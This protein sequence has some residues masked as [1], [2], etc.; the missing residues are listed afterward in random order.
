MMKNARIEALHSAKSAAPGTLQ[1]LL[2][3]D[4]KLKSELVCLQCYRECQP[5]VEDLALLSG[6]VAYADRMVS[7]TT[8][9]GWGREIEILLPVSEPD[10]W[11]SKKVINSLVGALDLVTGDCWHIRFSKAPAEVNSHRQ[12]QF[13]KDEAAPPIVIPF[14]DGLDS[15]ATLRLQSTQEPKRPFVLVTVGNGSRN[16]MRRGLQL[17][18][19]SRL[20]FP[21]SMNDS[22]RKDGHKFRESSYRSRAFAYTV[23]AG[24]VAFLRNAERVVIPES[25]QGV[26]GPWLQ[27]VGNEALDIRTHPMFTSRVSDFLFEVIGKRIRFE[28]PRLFHTKAETLKEANLCNDEGWKR[29]RSCP[30]D[31]RY[32]SIDHHHY[33][34]GVCSACLLRRMAVWNAGLKEEAP[35]YWHNLAAATLREAA[36]PGARVPT[37][38]DERIARAGV[39]SHIQLA[40]YISTRGAQ[41]RIWQAAQELSELISIQPQ[42]AAH[43]ITR[44]VEQHR[45][46]WAA[47]EASFGENSMMSKW[48]ELVA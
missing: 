4:L 22:K 23:M 41:R 17:G 8:S 43:R 25:G 9:Q 29:T 45:A 31:Q 26:L 47:F 21:F 34:C 16:G 15:Y 33:Q 24:A 28:H 32:V 39:L 14:S 48:R 3:R 13:L 42:V 1:C 10:L 19:Q 2:P 11:S 18:A 27:P 30:R 38:N 6:V 44:L 46:E 7:R 5:V 20:F 36:Y 12:T 40:E 35:Y 37:D